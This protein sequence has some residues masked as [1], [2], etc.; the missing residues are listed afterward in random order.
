[1]R[2]QALKEKNASEMRASAAKRPRA[3][4]LGVVRELLGDLK[5]ATV[6]GR[7]FTIEKVVK[8]LDEETVAAARDLS[9][10]QRRGL[11]NALADLRSEQGRPSPRAEAFAIRVETMLWTFASI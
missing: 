8:I 4:R 11:A 2:Q 1:M 3:W 10:V 7:R 6:A 9:E 5:T